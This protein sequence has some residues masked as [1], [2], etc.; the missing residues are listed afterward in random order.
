MAGPADSP[1]RREI[2]ANKFSCQN[3]NDASSC[4]REDFLADFAAA[5]QLLGSQR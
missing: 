4:K 5:Q 2:A 1:T 3:K